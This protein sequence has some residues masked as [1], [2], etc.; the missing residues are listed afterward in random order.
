[1]L[2]EKAKEIFE[3][4][5]QAGGI[6][7]ALMNRIAPKIDS[8]DLL[9]VK[10]HLNKIK[11][12]TLQ[13]EISE[14]KSKTG[15]EFFDIE[16]REFYNTAQNYRAATATDQSQVISAYVELKKYIS[17]FVNQCIKYKSKVEPISRP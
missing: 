14:V 8:D 16:S 15:E 5:N 1:M 10:N 12:L 11:S 17:S 7:T 6:V 13:R 9:L 2:D 4:A 3:E